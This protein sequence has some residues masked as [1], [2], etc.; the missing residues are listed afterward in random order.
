MTAKGGRGRGRHGN[1]CHVDC[2]N[3]GKCNYNTGICTCFEGFYGANCGTP[4][5]AMHFNHA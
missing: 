4:I 2:S 5:S 1:I 3:R